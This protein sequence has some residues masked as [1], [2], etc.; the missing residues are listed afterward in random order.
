MFK[1]IKFSNRKEY[2]QFAAYELMR[3][4]LSIFFR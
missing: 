4:E 3:C 1:N 2:F